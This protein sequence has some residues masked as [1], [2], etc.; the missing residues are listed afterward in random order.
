[1][2]PLELLVHRCPEAVGVDTLQDHEGSCR[3]A[4]HPGQP[5]PAARSQQPCDGLELLTGVPMPEPEPSKP[6]GPVLA[7]RPASNGLL[8]ELVELGDQPARGVAFHRD[9]LAEGLA[10]PG[11]GGA[12]EAARPHLVEPS[13]QV[14]HVGEA[15]DG[16]RA[17]RAPAAQADASRGLG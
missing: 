15:R 14:E 6:E 3:S 7:P 9:A 5:E 16:D 12:A 4:L 1:V 8:H 17:R 11:S 2:V 13:V 10:D